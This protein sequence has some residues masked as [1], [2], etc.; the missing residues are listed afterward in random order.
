MANPKSEITPAFNF[1]SRG[2]QL[3]EYTLTLAR[4]Q[5]DLV[6]Q[7]EGFRTTLARWLRMQGDDFKGNAQ[8]PITL[9]P[10]TEGNARVGIRCTEEMMARIERQFGGDVLRADPPP[11]HARATVYP[12]KVD[13]WDVSKW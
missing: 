8:E 13:P 5:E 11:A 7:G 10:S 9:A 2:R 3:N 6:A 1:K 4:P 12:P